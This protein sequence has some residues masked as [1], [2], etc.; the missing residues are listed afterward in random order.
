MRASFILTKTCSAVET[1]R[2]LARTQST[3]V[4]KYVFERRRLFLLVENVKLII[5]TEHFII[6]RYLNKLIR[7]YNLVS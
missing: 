7:E 5:N 6:R 2:V 1:Q 4:E 3:V